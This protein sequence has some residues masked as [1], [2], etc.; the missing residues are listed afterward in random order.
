MIYLDN[1][2][3]SFPKPPVVW[4][5]M[6]DIIKNK[7][8]N[9]GRSGHRLSVEAGKIMWDTR[10]LLAAFLNADDPEE[11]I[12]TSNATEALNLAIKGCLKHGDHCITTS[13]EH[14]SV[15][16]PI[17]ELKPLGI[18]FDIVQADGQGI[19][20]PQDIRRAIQENT[21]LIAVTHGSNLTGSIQPVEEIG[22]ICSEAGVYYL[23]DAAQTAGI[24]PLDIK[25]MGADMV[26][27]PGHK[28]L[29]GPTGTGVLYLR[30]GLI[31][32]PLKVGGTGGQSETLHQPLNSPDRYE[33]G[34]PNT[35]GIAG[36]QAGLKF[37]ARVGV[38]NI[39]AKEKELLALML[40]GLRQYDEVEIYG[41]EE[42]AYRLPVVA[43]NI[44][45]ADASEV[46]FILDRVYDIAVR[47]GLHCAPLAHRTMGTLE[48]GAIR[49]SLSYF[50]E[51][52]E[53][54][55]FIGAIGSIIKDMA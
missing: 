16:R 31:L 34:T 39:E 32:N 12:F 36:L 53:V 47:T 6:E 23:V 21:R 54:E 18:E 17:H 52:R 19:V 43:F 28:G 48:K 11:I 26:A 37:V 29:Y 27:L 5:A 15:A 44:K 33:S 51:R 50:N 22:A 3:T 24:L 45:E 10:E 55:F 14:N 13:M 35:V 46:G 2:A 9:P 7:G 41:P 20:K 8:A 1:A 25:K 38:R 49:A 40:A 42:I 4:E 30:K